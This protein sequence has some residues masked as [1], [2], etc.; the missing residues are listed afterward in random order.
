MVKIRNE[1]HKAVDRYLRNEENIKGE[2]KTKKYV[3]RKYHKQINRWERRVNK[4][5]GW[6]K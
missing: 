3:I 4:Q 6:I 2:R 1:H 5:T